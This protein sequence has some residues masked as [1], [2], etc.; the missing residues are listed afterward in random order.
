MFGL[1]NIST[2][3][4]CSFSA[5]VQ[6]LL[7]CCH[8]NKFCLC[9][10]FKQ[11]ALVD[12]ICCQVILSIEMLYLK[13]FSLLLALSN[14]LLFIQVVR[15]IIYKLWLVWQLFC[16]LLRDNFNTKHQLQYDQS[17]KV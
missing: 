2:K 7:V 15:F 17:Q 6:A 4:S 1:L 3:P 8:T 12:F 16:L 9:Y 5:Y 10:E 13:R 11:R 14:H